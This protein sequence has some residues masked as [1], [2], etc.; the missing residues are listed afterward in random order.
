MYL[1]WELAFQPPFSTVLNSKPFIE[2]ARS[3]IKSQAHRLKR[4]KS[5]SPI[6]KTAT[7]TPKCQ[8]SFVLD[9]MSDSIEV[10]SWLQEI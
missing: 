5:S 4:E 9:F 7:A 6:E 10:A 8:T 1:G 2:S 3:E